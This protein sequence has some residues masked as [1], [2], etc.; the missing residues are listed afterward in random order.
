M[1]SSSLRNI[2]L[3]YFLPVQIHTN[4]IVVALEQIGLAHWP[5]PLKKITSDDYFA[6]CISVSG[7]WKAY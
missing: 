6:L 3:I 5:R 4:R 1:N 2:I 7:A